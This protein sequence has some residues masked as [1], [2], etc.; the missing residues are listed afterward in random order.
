[1]F[2]NNRLGWKGLPGTNTLAYYENSKITALKSFITSAPDLIQE[3]GEDQPPPRS[4][5][6]STSSRRS[7]SAAPRTGNGETNKTGSEEINGNN[8]AAEPPVTQVSSTAAC[9]VFVQLGFSVSNMPYFIK[10]NVHT[11]AVRT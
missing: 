8:G 3:V 2:T 9:T 5:L 11:R 6:P 10:Y 4:R 1:M 7:D